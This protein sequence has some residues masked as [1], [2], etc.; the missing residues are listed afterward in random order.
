ML[1]FNN[2]PV[3]ILITIPGFQ[4]ILCCYSTSTQTGNKRLFTTFISIHFILLFNWQIFNYFISLFVSI[5]SMLLFNFPSRKPSHKFTGISI[6]FML[7]FNGVYEDGFQKGF[8]FQHIIC[9]YSTN[10]ILFNFIKSR[11]FQYIICCYSTINKASLP[12][13]FP[14][15]NTS[16]VIIQLFRQSSLP[17]FFNTSYVII[18]LSG[19]T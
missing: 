12:R 3:G 14:N 13:T 11:P 9:C 4:Y 10:T 19:D 7:L 17:L 15:F 6:H 5:H 16:Y 8:I 18:Q 1:L 2:V